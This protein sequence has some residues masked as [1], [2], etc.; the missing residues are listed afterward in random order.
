MYVIMIYDVNRKRVSKVLRIARKY[1][2]WVQRSVFEGRITEKDFNELR[3]E[4]QNIIVEN[5]DSI[6]WYILKKEFVPYRHYIGEPK[7]TIS[8]II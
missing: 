8:S 1:L 6:Y 4:I 7:S 5:E 3:M 2:R